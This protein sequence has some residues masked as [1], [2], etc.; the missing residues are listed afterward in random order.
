MKSE[1]QKLANLA[2]KKAF[3]H[4]G[5]PGI[6]DKFGFVRYGGMGFQKDAA[7]GTLRQKIDNAK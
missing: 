2:G 4:A 6:V 3:V 5:I 7:T 1:L